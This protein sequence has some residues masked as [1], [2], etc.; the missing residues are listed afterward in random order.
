MQSPLDRRPPL[1]V[2]QS[3]KRRQMGYL[4]PTPQ[5]S[6]SS[7]WPKALASHGLIIHAIR[8]DPSRPNAIDAPSNLSG[9]DPSGA[10]Q[11]DAEYQPTDLV[12][13]RLSHGGRG[14]WRAAAV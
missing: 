2:A 8:R 9:A 1:G 6:W 7:G 12:V 10:D 11:I 13:Q 3:A 14:A 5:W 4:M